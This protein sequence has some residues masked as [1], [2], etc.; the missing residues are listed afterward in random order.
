MLGEPKRIGHAAM[1]IF[2]IINECEINASL[3]EQEQIIL[4]IASGEISREVFTNWLTTK[5]IPFKP[6]DH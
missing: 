2:L 3:E 6:I 5:I 4:K 1:E